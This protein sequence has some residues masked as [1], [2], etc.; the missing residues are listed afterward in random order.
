MHK[1][2]SI[3]SKVVTKGKEVFIAPTSTVLG[4][5]VLGDEVSIWFG[6]VMRGDSDNIS[7][8][9]KSNVQDNAV[10]HCDPGYPAIIGN[11]CIVGHG[12]IVH[13]A[14]L[15]NN[16]LIGMH[17]TILNGAEVGD[18][19]I[20]GANAL[21]TSNTII[22]PRSLVL[23]S[24]AKVIREITPEEEESI[25]RNAKAYM[26]LSKEYIELYKGGV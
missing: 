10:V 8:G 19:C 14:K 22:K 15:G 24:P 1:K 25:R 21:V 12:A 7:I 4:D 6:A 16:V 23:G 11:E 18:F 26:D 5:V 13:G 17:A 20:I 2:R 3:L 9:N